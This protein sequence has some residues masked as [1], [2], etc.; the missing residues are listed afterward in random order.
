MSKQFGS[1]T[2]PY[3]AEMR[4]QL[5]PLCCGAQ[6]I[7]G[8]KSVATETHEELVAKINDICT[9]YVADHQ[10]Y[11]G[12]TMKPTVCFLTLNGGQMMSA[13]IISA[14]EAAGFKL[15]ATGTDRGSDQGFFVRNKSGAFKLVTDG[16][17]PIRGSK[18]NKAKIEEPQAA[19]S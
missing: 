7:S 8:F 3:P 9:N 16:G 18:P 10:V 15:F 4:N 14:V 13:K 17:V 6:I 11:T 5:W 2:T 12:E 1:N 19:V